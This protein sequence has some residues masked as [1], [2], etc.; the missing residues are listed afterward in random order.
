M[1]PRNAPE[2]NAPP[3]AT[4]QRIGEALEPPKLL[5]HAKLPNP[6]RNGV[7]LTAGRAMAITALVRVVRFL[8][9]AP[10]RARLEPL[11][12]APPLLSV[13]RACWPSFCVLP[14]LPLPA[15]CMLGML[16]APAAS[17]AAAALAVAALAFAAAAAADFSRLPGCAAVAKL[18]SRRPNHERERERK[19]ATEGSHGPERF[20][21]GAPGSMARLPRSLSLLSTALLDSSPRPHPKRCAHAASH[22]PPRFKIRRHRFFRSCAL[23]L[24]LPS[25]PSC[26]PPRT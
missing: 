16:Q 1:P 8:S 4:P 13:S 26:P 11:E 9:S 3:Q 25:S 24:Q 18:R 20:R 7:S 10:A 14:R 22:M 21:M 6:A 17:L 5:P 2:A 19:R 12:P 15:P 23:L